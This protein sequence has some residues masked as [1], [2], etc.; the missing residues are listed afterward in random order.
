MRVV[1]RPCGR[2]G[3]PAHVDLAAVVVDFAADAVLEDGVVGEDGALVA[4]ELHLKQPADGKR[5]DIV[6]LGWKSVYH[7]CMQSKVMLV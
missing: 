5:R 4:M 7:R 6:R 2:V 3:Q 1:R